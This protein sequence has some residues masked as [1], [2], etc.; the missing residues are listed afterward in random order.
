MTRPA[1][2]A[3]QQSHFT[4]AEVENADVGAA[5]ADADADGHSNQQ[6]FLAGTDP[7]DAGSILR[8]TAMRATGTGVELTWKS[9]TGKAYHIEYGSSIGGYAEVAQVGANGA[10]TSYLDVAS[11]TGSGFYRVRLAL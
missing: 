11:R 2:D 3:W 5:D 10:T 4:A 8:V 1:F 9:C 7:R 6:E